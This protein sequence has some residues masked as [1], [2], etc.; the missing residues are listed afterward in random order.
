MPHSLS[1]AT[2]GTKGQIVIPQDVREK[3]GV[4]PGDK[5]LILTRGG[6]IAALIPMDS[7]QELLEKMSANFDELKSI[8]QQEK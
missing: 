7:A 1:V 8:V 4:G 2:I 5:V 3:L 6:C